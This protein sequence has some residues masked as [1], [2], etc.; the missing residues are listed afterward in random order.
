MRLQMRQAALNRGTPKNGVPEPQ[1]RPF[2]L[3]FLLVS[4]AS[5]V[6]AKHVDRD[7]VDLIWFPTGGG[8]TEAYL[9]LA[10]I[11]IFRHA[12]WPTARPAAALP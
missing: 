7:V 8:K 5:T 12:G 2:Q 1:W 4:L 10:A 9:G 3:G 11:E 6:D